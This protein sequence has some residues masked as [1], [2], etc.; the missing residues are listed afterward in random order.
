MFSCRIAVLA[1]LIIWAP[2]AGMAQVRGADLVGRVTDA[3]GAGIDG[4]EIE[5]HQPATGS[6]RT[7]RSGGSGDYA[8]PLLDPGTHDV[9]VRHPGFVAQ[10]FRLSLAAGERARLD[11]QL[12]VAPLAESLSVMATV[13]TRQADSAAHSVLLSDEVVARAPLNGRNVMRLVQMIPGATE[14]LPNALSSGNRPDDRRLTSAVSVNGQTDVVNNHLIDGVD[15]NERSIGAPGIRP[16]VEAIAE[17]RVHTHGYPAEL[18]RTAGAVINLITKGGTNEWRGSAFEF[19]R[20]DR[21][22]AR[23]FF[24]PPGSRPPLRQHQYGGSIGGPLKRDRAFIFADL[25][26][27][28]QVQGVPLVSTVPTALMRQ[29]NFSEVAAPLYD[30]NTSPRAP[31]PGN[32]IPPDRIDPVAARLIALYPFPTAA[33]LANNYTTVRLRRQHSTAGDARLDFRHRGSHGTTARYSRNRVTTLTPGA[34]PAVGDIEPG[35]QAG[36]FAGPSHTGGDAAAA[37]HLHV[38]RTDLLL[39]ARAG[40]I[41]TSTRSLPL[42]YGNR[43]SE[44]LGLPGINV[45]ERTSALSQVVVSGYTTL[46][47]AGFLPLVMSG[48]TWQYTGSLLRVRD[49]H[50]VKIGGGVIDRRFRVAQSNSPVGTFTFT[51]APTSN[52]SGTGGHA[53]AS[54]LLGLPAQV[55]RSHLLVEPH[56][57][58][59]E[60]HVYAQD[61]WRVASWLTLNVGVRYDV[62]T[63]LVEEHNQLSNFDPATGRVLVA[64]TEGVSRSAGVAT[65]LGNLAPRLGA[66]ATLPGEVI[67]R[68]G[69]GVA[70]YP[71]NYASNALLRNHPF[72]FTHGPLTSAAASGEPPTLHLSE[73]LPAPAP[74]G[75]HAPAGSLIAVDRQFRAT[76]LHQFH[77]LVD[78]DIAGSTAT[79]AYIGSLGRRVAFVIPNINLAPPGPGAVDPRRPYAASLPG[80]SAIGLMTSSGRSSYHALQASLARRYSGGVSFNTHYTWAHAL[81]TAPNVGGG[82]APAGFAVVPSAVQ[83]MEHGPSDFDVRHRW[84]LLATYDVPFAHRG[85]AFRTAILGGWQVSASA[86]WQSG[87]PFTV[88]N[89]TPRSNTGVGAN[90]DRP[91]RVGSGR[92]SDPGIERWFDTSAFAAQPFGTVGNSGR[93]ILHGPPTRRLDVALVKQVPVSAQARLEMRLEGF[94]VTNTPSFAL[95]NAALGSPGFGTITSTGNSPARQIQVAAR[96]TF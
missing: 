43:A 9:W 83:Q 54:L 18:G 52:G 10:R 6:A 8:V 81:S 24:A 82:G 60:P 29:G 67:L 36:G 4:A 49:G 7:A 61:D 56:Y 16:S 58:T 80:V 77:A 93:N 50:T 23:N 70:Y 62:F 45:D 28:S 40:Y 22:D 90:G 55:Q 38:F 86:V 14:G 68:G 64:G 44:R 76:A 53:V 26:R 79:A 13:P 96:L 39:E 66:A 91:N 19:Y 78:A 63:P 87:V 48:G 11:A 92:V 65:D 69:Y 84:A 35:G 33:G 46:G 47:D 75:G 41:G 15:N 73:G 95:P 85:G 74:P 59:L 42:N 51:A 71:G 31:F 88:V 89:A 25:E 72:V 32:V 1:A 2:C 94:N 5:V 27:F 37:T 30:P 34:F 20:N 57:R 21:M 12:V 17:V 3:S